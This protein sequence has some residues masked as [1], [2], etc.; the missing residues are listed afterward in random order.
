MSEMPRIWPDKNVGEKM[1][2]AKGGIRLHSE[3]EY[4]GF[5]GQGDKA[6]R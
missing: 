1:K 2:G 6:E 3:E 4:G 5:E